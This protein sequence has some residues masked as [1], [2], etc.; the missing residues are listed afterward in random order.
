MLEPPFVRVVVSSTHHPLQ[1]AF[2]TCWLLLLRQAVSEG[3]GASDLRARLRCIAADAIVRDLRHARL[4]YLAL[5]PQPHASAS[6]TASQHADAQSVLVT[7]RRV[8]STLSALPD[9]HPLYVPPIYEC[10]MLSKL[11]L[12][13]ILAV[14]LRELGRDGKHPTGHFVVGGVEGTG[15]TTILQAVAVAVAVCS[16]RYFLVY[17]DYKQLPHPYPPARILAEVFIRVNESDFASQFGTLRSCAGRATTLLLE[18]DSRLD[19]AVPGR[20]V[21]LSDVLQKMA[22]SN[23]SCRVGLIADEIQEKVLPHA[24]AASPEVTLLR[25]LESF[26]RHSAGALLVLSGSSA[27][28]RAR[29]FR[30]ERDIVYDAYPDFNQSL[31]SYYHVSALRTL[32]KLQRYL[33]QRYS[34]MFRDSALLAHTAEV[35][36]HRTGGIG[37]LVHDA[38]MTPSKALARV[39]SPTEEFVK[40]D[41]CLFVLVNCIRRHVGR[42][43]SELEV[44]ISAAA[45]SSPQTLTPAH[46]G[47]PFALALAELKDH[48]VSKPEHCIQRWLD[49][50]L[51]YVDN[52]KQVQLARPIDAMDYFVGQPSAD[53]LLLLQLVSAMVQRPELENNAGKPLERLMRPRIHALLE[54]SKYSGV[55]SLESSATDG[56]SVW[57]TENDGRKWRVDIES[58]VRLDNKNVRWINETGLDGLYFRVLGPASA[59]TVTLTVNGWQCKGGASS[60]DLGGGDIN[61]YRGD[62]PPRGAGGKSRGRRDSAAARAAC[63]RA[64]GGSGGASD[65]GDTDTGTAIAGPRLNKGD[66]TSPA[67]NKYMAAIAHNAELGFIKLARA[68]LCSTTKTAAGRGPSLMIKL[69]ALTVTSTKGAGPAREW[70]KSNSRQTIPRASVLRRELLSAEHVDRCDLTYDVRLYTGLVWFLDNLEEPLRRMWPIA[71]TTSRDSAEV[72]QGTEA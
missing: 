12:E 54:T 4:E 47:M 35:L 39:Y 34:D 16:A 30:K 17:V 43:S 45:S 59:S 5:G 9:I 6:D 53:D 38:V 66:H 58:L 37:R 68:L 22:T 61:G 26:A 57:I 52:E 27:N 44:A 29:L 11:L 15:K 20:V 49:M 72:E 10:E 70:L 7:F 18:L 48:H 56:E 64:E 46:V 31:T 28:L 42:T 19:G 65:S 62:K 51:L 67:A 14:R 36:L 55:L 8:W 50:G 2:D 60:D 23:L 24:L 1:D 63:E 71:I 41:G 3:D 69:G 13:L 32:P 40:T 25:D 21:K 33:S